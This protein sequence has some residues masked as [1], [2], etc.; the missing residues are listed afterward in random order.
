MEF[1]HA[2]IEAHFER[3]ADLNRAETYA[4][5]LA[6]L[7]LDPALPDLADPA[8]AEAAWAEG[9]AMGLSSYPTLILDRGDGAEVL[10]TTYDPDALLRILDDGAR[11]PAP[12]VRS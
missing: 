4:P 3:G 6:G 2:V 9:R 10:P 8:L 11:S 1:A 7:G 12:A 5:L